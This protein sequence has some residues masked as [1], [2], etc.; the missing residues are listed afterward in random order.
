M[1]QDTKFLVCFLILGLFLS[2]SY[3]QDTAEKTTE[4]DL[5]SDRA[6]ESTVRLVGTRL[7]ESNVYLDGGTGFFVAPDKIATNFHVT[8]GP[9][10]GPIFAKLD[11]KETI[12]RVEGVWTFDAK[13]DIAILKLQGEGK[14]L[15]LVDVDTLKI[16]ETVYL[17]GFPYS[18][19]YKVV[20]GTLKDIRSSDRWLKTTV[21][22]YPGNSGS[23]MLNRKGE[24]IGIHVGHG[25]DA[26]PANAITALLESSTSTEPLEEWRKRNV[27]RAYVYHNE[28]TQKFYDT[29]YADAIKNFNQAIEL[30]P[31][32]A[33]TYKFRAQAKN[34]LGNHKGALE[35]YN[36]L[37]KLNPENA[38]VYI[39]RGDV[40]HK[41]EDYKGAIG[42]YS[43]AIRLD[44]DN[45]D[46]YKKRG[47]VKGEI[48]DQKGKIEDYTIVI[49]LKSEAA[50]IKPDA[51]RYNELGHLKESVGD[52]TGAIED[53]TKAIKLQPEDVVYG[54]YNRGWARHH[55]GD[56]AGAI[57]DFTKAI[58][59]KPE[60]TLGTYFAYIGRGNAKRISKNLEGALADYNQAIK[61]QPENPTAYIKRGHAKV[62]LK[63]YQGAIAD[64][65]K[66]IELHPKSADA[67]HNRGLAKKALGQ[68]DAAKID[69]EKA[70]EIDPNVGE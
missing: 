11:H 70:K 46:V 49:K 28:G 21:K 61:L 27:V 43:H 25:Y 5:V 38:E 13:S 45:A 47:N 31:E 16:G 57:E 9:T 12:W 1:R 2:L 19:E 18:R 40:K 36:Q 26:R 66:A 10:N 24:A 14:P 34:R 35:D 23:P 62:T 15:T 68:H 51:N 50:A 55:F 69:F 22:A 52:H 65:S 63:D 42:D 29:Q 44:P 33:E 64:Y 53:F 59:L 20:D 37:I 30:S 54:Y 3:A 67:Y 17:A 7:K 32:D 39:N 41:I 8:A 4:I 6:K 56:H 48:G 58:K 60:D